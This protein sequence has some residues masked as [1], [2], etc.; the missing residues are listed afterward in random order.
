MQHCHMLEHEDNEVLSA[1]IEFLDDRFL[2]A[3]KRR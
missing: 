1:L 2:K 3:C